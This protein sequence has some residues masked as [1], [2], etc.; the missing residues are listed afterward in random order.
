VVFPA[1]QKV[2]GLTSIAH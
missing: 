2:I 1:S